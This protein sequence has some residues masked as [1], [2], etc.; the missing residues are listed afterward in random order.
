MRERLDDMVVASAFT[1]DLP[2]ETLGDG[3]R[4]RDLAPPLRR[5]IEQ[6][7]EHRGVDI[8][9]QEAVRLSTM[10]VWRDGQLMPRP[11][12]LR[13]FLT[14][15]GDG[16]TVMPGGFV[17]IGAHEDAY[18]ISLQR[19]ALTADAW[20]SS[21]RPD[22]RDDAAAE[23]GPRSPS[24]APPASC[25]AAPPTTCSGSAATSSAPRRR[26]GSFARCSTGWRKA[27]RPS[28]MID[29]IASLIVA[30]DASSEGP[31]GDAARS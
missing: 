29:S 3:V 22:A 30:W 16:W 13:V 9:L 25:R 10:P 5:R 31:S 21:R 18:A 27:I 20:I 15:H 4:G 23:P 7:I 17:R 12:I 26:C 1:G 14:R 8:V 6:S 24:S 19:G 11:F 28:D 2:S